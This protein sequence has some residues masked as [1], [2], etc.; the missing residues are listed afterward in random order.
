MVDDEFLF[1]RRKEYSDA[2]NIYEGLVKEGEIVKSS[3]AR[4]FPSSTLKF[5]Q[6][7]LLSNFC[8]FNSLSFHLKWN[9]LCTRN[10][11]QIRNV[12]NVTRP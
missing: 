8:N 9:P 11:Y 2:C 5:E 3:G 10:V 4:N 7:W 12:L 1:L 6:P